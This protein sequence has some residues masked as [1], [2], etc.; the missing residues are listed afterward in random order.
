MANRLLRLT[1]PDSTVAAFSACETTPGALADWVAQLPMAHTAEAA[2]QLLKTATEVARL[3]ADPSSRFNFLEIIRA[4]AHYICTRLDRNAAGGSTSGEGHAQLAQ[5]LQNELALGYK[6]VIQNAL[7]DGEL[8]GSQ[9]D[10]VGHASHRALADLSFA[11]RRT[12]EFYTDPPRRVWYELNQLYALAEELGLANSA[13]ADDQSRSAAQLTI[14]D[15]YLRIAMLAVAKPNQLRQKDLSAVYHALE[16][17]TPRLS[18]GAPTDDTLFVVDLDADAP[19]SY[20]EIGSHTGELLRGIRTDVLVYELEAYLTEMASDV[21]VPDYVSAELLRHL[22]HAWGVMKK[23]SFRRSHS[24]GPMKIC[25]GLR[26]LHYYISGGVD[27]AD[28]LGTTEA[29]LRREINPFIQTEEQ[30]AQKKTAKAGDVWDGAF[31]L[32][33]ARIPENP[34]IEDPGRILLTPRRTQPRAAGVETN[35]PCYD[36][37]IVD[38]SPSGYC[39]R[40]EAPLPPNL[41]TGELLAVRERDD[42][43]WCI[44]VSR[45][46]RHSDEETLLGLELLAPRAIP[47]AVRLLQKRGSSTEYNRGVLLP[48]LEAIGQPAMLITP[49]LPFRESQKVQI[50]RHSIQATG[51]L[52]RRVRMTESFT[53]FTFRML[54][55]YLEST[56]IDL[57][58][59]SLWDMIGADPE[60][61]PSN[62][63]STGPAK[64]KK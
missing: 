9:R 29:L 6:V 3:S 37:Q 23:R 15:V 54:D 10:L 22:A 53:Q 8:T 56:Q 2:Q 46:I 27:F 26:T 30:P 13:Y 47:V 17:W 43:R 21:P 34:N 42:A 57:N 12:Y 44:A 61:Q 58:M 51:Q 63:P 45:W 55:G 35:F 36:T 19:P 20:R 5:S 64:G 7:A 31:D 39:V 40:W 60:P 18:I 25:I 11:L 59:E 62:G 50:R 4:P 41:Q 49:R 38:T 24:S 1:V 28:Q 52:M 33:G 14:A 32:R 48:A 16:H